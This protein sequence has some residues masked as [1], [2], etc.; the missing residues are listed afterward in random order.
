MGH[1][2]KWYHGREFALLWGYL[3]NAVVD[4]PD[5]GEEENT[6]TYYRNY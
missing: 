2:G 3:G 6:T 1:F 5:R 4:R